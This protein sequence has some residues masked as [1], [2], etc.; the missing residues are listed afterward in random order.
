MA[1]MVN[2]CNGMNEKENINDSESD[3]KLQVDEITSVQVRIFI[4][5]F[6]KCPLKDKL[7]EKANSFCKS[8][9]MNVVKIMGRKYFWKC[10]VC[11]NKIHTLNTKRIKSKCRKCGAD[12]FKASL[13]YNISNAKTS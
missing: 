5:K 13:A 4:C 8:H 2:V 3:E 6:R 10:G 12:Q 1:N 9:S 11:N 7:T